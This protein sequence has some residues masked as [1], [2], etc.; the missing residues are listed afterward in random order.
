[1]LWSKSSAFGPTKPFP[2]PVMPLVSIKSWNWQLPG[3]SS[4]ICNSNRV[5]L[6]P[7]RH[8]LLK[9]EQY[10]SHMINLLEGN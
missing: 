10:S 8:Y 5:L 7:N 3:P 1:M 6:D 9:R 4:D 2:G